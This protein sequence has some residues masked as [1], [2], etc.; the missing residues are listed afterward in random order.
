MLLLPHVGVTKT[1]AYFTKITFNALMIN[2]RWTLDACISS[3]YIL[4]LA[5]DV[6]YKIINH[7][8]SRG[9]NERWVEK[10]NTRMLLETFIRDNKMF[11]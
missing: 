6:H 3:S 10:Y 9:L 1:L 4:I 7:H 11:K 2:I 5:F 8:R